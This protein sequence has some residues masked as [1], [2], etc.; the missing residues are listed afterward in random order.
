M[1]DEAQWIAKGL[2][3]Y[4]LITVNAEG[5]A[6]QVEKVSYDTARRLL[7]TRRGAHRRPSL[8]LSCRRDARRVLKEF[9]PELTAKTAKMDSDPHFWMP[10]RS[11]RRRTVP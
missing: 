5:E 9:E 7:A 2:E 11:P 10:R 3:K 1:P 4:G 6:A 8:G